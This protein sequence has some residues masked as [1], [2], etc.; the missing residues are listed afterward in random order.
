MIPLS[1]HTFYLPK[2]RTNTLYKTF[3]LI[4]DHRNYKAVVLRALNKNPSVLVSK[5]CGINTI[6]QS[7]KENLIKNG[8][9]VI[10]LIQ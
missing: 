6:S 9:F 3:L 8:V 7:A 5:L 4:L 10:C 2:S 1:Y